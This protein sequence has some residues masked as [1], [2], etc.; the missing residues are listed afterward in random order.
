MSKN[1]QITVN[2]VRKKLEA[3]GIT[4]ENGFLITET[5]IGDLWKII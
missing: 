1:E 3:V 2:I 4:A 5:P